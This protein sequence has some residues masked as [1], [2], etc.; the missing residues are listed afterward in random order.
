MLAP[1]VSVVEKKVS[2]V[3][4]AKALLLLQHLVLT[5]VTRAK[6]KEKHQLH[7]ELER[8]AP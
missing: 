6:A 4:K 1:K 5:V 3:E 8:L 2:V 7:S